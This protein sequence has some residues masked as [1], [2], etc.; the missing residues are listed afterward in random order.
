MTVPHMPMMNEQG[1]LECPFCGEC[2]YGV[3]FGA[4]RC[5]MVC[6]VRKVRGR[7]W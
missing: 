2:S 3:F 1:L 5:W 4:K 7:N 6:R